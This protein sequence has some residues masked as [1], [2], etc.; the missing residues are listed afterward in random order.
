MKKCSRCGRLGLFFYIDTN[1]ICEKCAEKEAKQKA[2][3]D[4]V[5]AQEFVRKISK[6]FADIAESGVQLPYTR[7][8]SWTDTNDIPYHTA[9][10]LREDCQLISTELP[11]WKEYPRFIDALLKDAIPEGK[12]Q[13]Y[14]QHPFIPLGTLHGEGIGGGNDFSK[15]IP[16]ILERVFTLDTALALYGKYEYKIYRIVGA[17]YNNEDGT[18]R[19][20]I[21]NKIK[22][23]AKPFQDETEITLKKYK[24]QDE[25]AVAVYANGLQIGHISRK[26]LASSFLS[27]WDRYDCVADFELVGGSGIYGMDIFV[28][29]YKE[30]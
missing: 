27:R 17:S 3:T 30:R 1:G 2:E 22:R 28:R 10:R 5:A 7:H 19:M 26:D 12:V 21:M 11:K 24:Y 9:Q 14:Y 23:K 6:A 8:I 4:L 25:D 16:E 18:N 13:G 29:F 15:E 20:A